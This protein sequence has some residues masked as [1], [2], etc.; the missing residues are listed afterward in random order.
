MGLRSAC[1]AIA[2]DGIG[3]P[4]GALHLNRDQLVTVTMFKMN[5]ECHS[6]PITV[7]RDLSPQSQEIEQNVVD[8]R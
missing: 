1:L 5:A 4:N 7:H 6:L 8:V 3:L 2:A